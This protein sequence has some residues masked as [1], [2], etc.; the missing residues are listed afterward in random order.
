[1]LKT[2]LTITGVLSCVFGF[3]QDSIVYNL[4]EVYTENY[5]NDDEKFAPATLSIRSYLPNSTTLGY[6]Q[7]QVYNTETN[8]FEFSSQQV[9]TFDEN[10]NPI[11]AQVITLDS[12]GK[13]IVSTS[14]TTSYDQY[15][16][17][18][19]QTLEAFSDSLQRLVP[20]IRIFSYYKDSLLLDS[21]IQE[22]WD[23][24]EETWVN[25]TKAYPEY[26]SDNKRIFEESLL[27]NDTIQEFELNIRSY[28]TYNENNKISV[29]SSVYYGFGYALKQS[30]TFNTFD[31]FGR[32]IN[33]KVKQLNFQVLELFDSQE[34]DYSYDSDDEDDTLFT[35]T[36]VAVWIDRE[37][38]DTLMNEYVYDLRG[39]R[40][41][42]VRYNS[43]N[44]IIYKPVSRSY[45]TY[46]KTVIGTEERPESKF[47]LSPNPTT[48]Y[49]NIELEEGEH[50]IE[51]YSL[52]GNKVY[53]FT[54]NQGRYTLALQGFSAGTYIVK[55][56]G[57]QS[58]KLI[59]GN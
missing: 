1:M 23:R 42:D 59:I 51:I 12:T 41:L 18:E 30:E 37:R 32:I 34:V 46:E 19:T 57:N 24:D 15:G 11:N 58:K 53:D 50:R 31:E 22:E 3:S 29:D 8:V 14:I 52:T 43:E 9:F 4:V 27:W 2:F 47:K 21:L 7:N 49:V 5:D 38:K 36:K 17:A 26:N 39:N 6:S 40:I 48:S 55:V 54:T 20:T 45:F 13:E 28:T 56:D 10:D 44:G 35:E 33:R 16:N 25:G